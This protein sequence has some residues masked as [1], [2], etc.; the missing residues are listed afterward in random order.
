[1]LPISVN[2]LPFNFVP[3]NSSGKLRLTLISNIPLSLTEVV[4]VPA[5]W[6]RRL[7]L[8]SGD[9][10]SDANIS[11]GGVVAV[12]LEKEPML[13]WIHRRDKGLGG[14]GEWIS[15]RFE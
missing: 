8:L 13:G 11:H 2:I 3:G 12:T 1:V 15:G 7:T 10:V 6:Y 14:F 5:L 4:V 9:P